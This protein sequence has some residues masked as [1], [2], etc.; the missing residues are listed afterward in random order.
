MRNG[1]KKSGLWLF[2][3][4]TGFTGSRSH[5]QN[6]AGLTDTVRIHAGY[7]MVFQDTTFHA[8]RDTFFIFPKGTDFRIK[9]INSFQSDHIYERLKEKQDS[10]LWARGI[11]DLIIREQEDSAKVNPKVNLQNSR[12]ELVSLKVGYIR[13]IHV[14]MI[15]ENTDSLSPQQEK[16]LT[17]VL[18][19]IHK[20]TR[21]SVIRKNLTV[22]EGDILGAFT[23]SDLEHHLRSLRYIEDV[24]VY[25]NRDSLQPGTVNLLV[26]V[27]DRLPFSVGI[28]SGGPKDLSLSVTDI[29][30]LGTG[31]GFTNVLHYNGNSRPLFRYSGHLSFRISGDHL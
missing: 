5:A 26:A 30:F 12:P 7:K 28:G 8:L 3:L 25:V 9:K 4:L 17:K 29:N 21:E 22:S 19:G 27:K 20:N 2:L 1:F 6:S 10:S 11:Y 15:F 24:K 14:D 18:I 13:I 23:I 31:N 16:V